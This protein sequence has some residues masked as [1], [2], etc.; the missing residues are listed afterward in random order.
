MISWYR[1]DRRGFLLGSAALGAATLAQPRLGRAQGSKVLRVRNYSDI[2]VLDPLDR[3]SNPEDDLTS[4]LLPKLIEWK[5]GDTWEWQLAEA[6]SIEQLDPLNIRFVLKE[7][8]VWSNGFGEVTAEDVKY[9]FERIA[10]PARE[11]PYKDD[12]SALDHVEV[13]DKLTGIIRLKEF[14][15]PLWTTTLPEGS[16]KIVCKAAVEA[17][18]DK[19]FTTEIPATCG[20]YMMKEWSPRQ[21]TTIVRDP[22]WTGAAPYYDEIQIY[23]IEDEKAAEVAYEAGEIDFTAVSLSSLAGYRK[24]PPAN[25]KIIVKPSLAYV[26]LGM[27]H[28]HPKLQDPR[29]RRAIQMAVDVDSALEAAYF[30]EAERATGIIAPGMP[31][32]REKNLV[33]RDVEGARKLLE[34][35]GVSGLQLTLSILNKTERLSVAQV[36]QANLAEIGIDVEI[37]PYESGVYWSLGDDK[38]GDAWKDI[39]LIVQRFSMTPDPSWATMWFVPEQIGVWN[40]ER[41]NNAEFGQLHNALLKEPD[42]AKRDADYKKMQDLM[43]N[44]GNYVFLTHEATAYICRDTVEP[45]LQPDGDEVYTEFKGA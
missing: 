40:W 42:V 24:N 8:L 36:I 12:W 25:T 27:N 33:E 6:Q 16:G 29:V 1:L 18:P 26:W 34:E 10:D 3:K 37:I 44:E 23:P 43:E 32:H 2:Q 13:V 30:G 35:A 31:G 39:Q 38:S 41:W 4:C 19:H 28:D 17:L 14:F 22:N 11:S 5:P 15:A 20:P 7:G 9:S 21:R 45:A